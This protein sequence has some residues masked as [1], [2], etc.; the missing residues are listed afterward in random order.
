[1]NDSRRILRDEFRDRDYREAYAEDF[2]STSIATQIKVIREQRQLSQKGFGELIG[3]R[4]AGVSRFENVNYSKWSVPLLRKMA[5]ALGCRLRVS[6]ETFGSLLDEDANFSVE[7]LKRPTFEED[8]EFKECGMVGMRDPEW[9]LAE[10]M[11]VATGLG[12]MPFGDIQWPGGC[13]TASPGVNMRRVGR[14]QPAKEMDSSPFQ[15]SIAGHE[16][17]LETKKVAEGR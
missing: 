2:L 13:N 10:E 5:E 7:T 16:P 4:Q 9:T 14:S 1:M 11:G 6:F 8:P 15:Q 17:D 12:N 3:T